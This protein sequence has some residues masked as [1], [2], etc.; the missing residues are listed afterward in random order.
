MEISVCFSWALELLTFVELL[1][2]QQL[3]VFQFRQLSFVLFCLLLEMK[4]L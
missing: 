1:L 2:W 3:Q 4:M